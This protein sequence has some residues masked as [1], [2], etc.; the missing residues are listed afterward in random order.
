MP[1]QVLVPSGPLPSRLSGC[2]VCSCNTVCW[3]SGP[4]DK[5]GCHNPRPFLA[6]VCFVLLGTLW[7]NWQR[8]RGAGSDEAFISELTFPPFPERGPSAMQA[9]SLFGLNG[10]LFLRNGRGQLTG[11]TCE[12]VVSTDPHLEPS[13]SLALEINIVWPGRLTCWCPWPGA[14]RGGHSLRVAGSRGPTAHLA[15]ASD[16]AIVF[17]PSDVVGRFWASL[18]VPHPPLFG[19]FLRAPV[20]RRLTVTIG[21]CTPS[22]WPRWGTS[23]D[24]PGCAGPVL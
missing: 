21:F 14:G 24:D 10:A 13:P 6:R 9:G 11:S 7:K 18:V 12:H 22:K 23:S 20:E 1:K 15:L 19:T 3:G 8:R 2:C 5:L 16:T 4:R 17:L